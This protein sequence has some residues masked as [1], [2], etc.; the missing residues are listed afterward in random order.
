MQESYDSCI[1]F[2]KSHAI[3]SRLRH[4][5]SLVFQPSGHYISFLFVIDKSLKAAQIWWEI[6]FKTLQPGISKPDRPTQKCCSVLMTYECNHMTNQKHKERQEYL[7]LRHLQPLGKSCKEESI[8]LLHCLSKM[9]PKVFQSFSK[10]KKSGCTF[11]VQHC[12]KSKIQL[13]C[14][15][16]MRE[17][18]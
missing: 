13:Y 15:K 18:C 17:E 14:Q 3:T 1:R 10:G 2:F 8:Y 9:R 4:V 5:Q 16:P 6:S 12:Y 11:S 7:T